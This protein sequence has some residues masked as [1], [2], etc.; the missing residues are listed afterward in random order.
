MRVHPGRHMINDAAL[1]LSPP[2]ASEHGASATNQWTRIWSGDGVFTKEHAKHIAQGD[3]IGRKE[4]WRQLSSLNDDV[5]VDIADGSSFLW[6]LWVAGFGNGREQ[7]VIGSGLRKAELVRNRDEEKLVR[8]QRVD[9][10]LV[11][12]GLSYVRVR[13]NTWALELSIWLHAPV[14]P[15][16]Y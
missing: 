4:A 8:F 6:W 2:S 14:G 1:K 12:V 5:P 10:T 15:P 11:H 16:D 7:K 13:C 3:W 9:D